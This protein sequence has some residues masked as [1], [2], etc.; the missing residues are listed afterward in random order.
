MRYKDSV[1]LSFSIDLQQ[2]VLWIKEV[3]RPVAPGLIGRGVRNL[4]PECD[5]LL[6]AAIDL[7]R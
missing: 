5:Q 6:V 4:D 3:D 7:F 1:G 2:I